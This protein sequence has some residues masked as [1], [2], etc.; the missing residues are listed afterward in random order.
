MSEE[1]KTGGATNSASP[2]SSRSSI[3]ADSQGLDPSKAEKWQANDWKKHVDK[4]L[5]EFVSSC[6]GSSAGTSVED[7]N[8]LV[9]EGAH[10]SNQHDFSVSSIYF[11]FCFI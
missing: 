9:T 7:K 8:D 3:G 11:V 1:A 4:M 5:E 2:E 10:L 6:P